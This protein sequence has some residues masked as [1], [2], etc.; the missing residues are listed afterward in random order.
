MNIFLWTFLVLIATFIVYLVTGWDYTL[1]LRNYTLYSGKVSA[2]VRFVL[3]SDL[4]SSLYGA[5]Q[6]PLIDLITEQSPDAILMAGDMADDIIPHD[7]TI[8]FLSKLPQ[9]IPRFY[10]TGNHEIW[11]GEAEEIREMFRSY[12]V[13]VLQNQSVS[14][15]VN[16]Q[17]I[18]FSGVEDP[19]T[20]E[21]YDRQLKK[22]FASADPNSYT[23]LLAHRPERIETHLAYPCDLVVSG[24]AHGGQWRLPGI[25]NGLFAPNQGFFPR[26]AGGQYD[27]DNATMIVS[28]GL[29]KESTKFPRLYNPPEVVVIDLQPAQ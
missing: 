5:D 18:T 6:Q 11:S 19:T 24:H 17:T 4:H 8:T 15:Q 10:V 9:D 7:N 16:G 3:V 1:T 12:G 21:G 28:R 29:A 27:F 25:I 2:P 26:Y 20:K 13:T 23:V 14:L 22:T